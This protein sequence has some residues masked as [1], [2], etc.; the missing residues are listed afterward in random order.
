MEGIL[1][2]KLIIF[3]IYFVATHPHHQQVLPE[4]QSNHY[5]FTFIAHPR[6]ITGLVWRK[7]SVCMKQ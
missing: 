1:W 4:T 2:F 5:S 3:C 6:A 7:T